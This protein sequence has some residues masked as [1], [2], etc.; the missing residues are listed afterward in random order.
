MQPGDADADGYLKLNAEIGPIANQKARKGII[1]A[2]K[3]A[4]SARTLGRIRFQAGASDEGR[5]YS[6]FLRKN[7]VGLTDCYNTG[8]IE[9]NLVKLVADFEPEFELV[10]SIIPQFLRFGETTL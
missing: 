3:L 6:R 7:S 1:T 8:E 5:L 2:I 10:A 4:S 9:R